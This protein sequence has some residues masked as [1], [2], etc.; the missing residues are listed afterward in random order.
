MTVLESTAREEGWLHYQDH[1]SE[2]QA[3]RATDPGEKRGGV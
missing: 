1:E 3:A 2:D